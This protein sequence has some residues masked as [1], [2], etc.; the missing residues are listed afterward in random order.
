[1]ALSSDVL[2]NPDNIAAGGLSGDPGDNENAL[3]I[4]ALQ[5]DESYS[6]RKWT[7]ATVERP[8][9]AASRRTTMDDYYRSSGRRDRNYH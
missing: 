2:D 7:I 4:V 1:M 3:K 8:L 6:I 5:T 9:R